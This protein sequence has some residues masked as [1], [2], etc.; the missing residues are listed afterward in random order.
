MRT[1]YIKAIL[2]ILLL[3]RR[4]CVC[5]LQKLY[6]V[7][8]VAMNIVMS[9]ST[10]YSLESPKDPVLPSRCFTKPDKVGAQQCFELTS[11]A[12]VQR[13]EHIFVWQ[14]NLLIIL[15]MCLIWSWLL[16][17]L[18]QNFSNTKNYLPPEMKAFFT[19]GKVSLIKPLCIIVVFV[20]CWV[21]LISTLLVSFSPS[22]QTFWG[23][24]TSRWRRQ[25]NRSRAKLLAWRPPATTTPRQTPGPHSAARPGRKHIILYTCVWRQIQVQTLMSASILHWI[26]VQGNGLTAQSVKL[27]TQLCT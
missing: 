14:K 25:G 7:C 2:R 18:F 10:T 22:L 8:D 1:V 13:N 6:T 12:C 27:F 16:F 4:V 5:S 9:K 24:L 3:T 20:F 19:P 17:F 15:S 26:Q 21:E 11:R 23:Q